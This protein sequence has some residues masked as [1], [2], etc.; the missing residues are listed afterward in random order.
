MITLDNLVYGDKEKMR[1]KMKG[2][3]AEGGER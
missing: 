1:G 2:K 3:K